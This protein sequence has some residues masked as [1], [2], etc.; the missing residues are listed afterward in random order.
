MALVVITTKS[1]ALTLPTAMWAAL[2]TAYQTPPRA[3]HNIGHV[4]EVDAQRDHELFTGVHAA[5][6]PVAALRIDA[7]MEI[8]V[9]LVRPAPLRDE[10]VRA[11]EEGRRRIEMARRIGEPA[12]QVLVAVPWDLPAVLVSYFGHG[13]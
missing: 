6:N 9:V 4:H 11:V 7:G 10:I 5:S 2:E 13:R 3:Y 1:H 12:V 8:D